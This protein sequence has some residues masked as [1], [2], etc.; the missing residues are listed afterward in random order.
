MQSRWE[1][2]PTLK[3]NYHPPPGQNIFLLAP[4]D[5]QALVTSCLLMGRSKVPPPP[6]LFHS[7]TSDS[8]KGPSLDFWIE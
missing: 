3:P 6:E 5:F 8:P 4:T 2:T 1:T 7:S